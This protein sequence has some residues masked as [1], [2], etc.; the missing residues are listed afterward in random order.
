MA[1]GHEQ[2]KPLGEPGRVETRGIGYRVGGDLQKA[3]AAVEEGGRDTVPDGSGEGEGAIGLRL[4]RASDA[5][6]TNQQ[7]DRGDAPGEFGAHRPANRKGLPAGNGG[8]ASGAGEAWGREVEVQA[9]A[10]EI[11]TTT[12]VEAEGPR[13]KE[14]SGT[15]ESINSG[16]ERLSGESNCASRTPQGN[17][18][19]GA[20]VEG[21]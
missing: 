5:G 2:E 20:R 14:G 9:K 11:G 15:E 16:I 10:G 19:A 6:G 12:D 21:A 4:D 18:V 13:R 17:V 3:N 8:S 1:D 7:I